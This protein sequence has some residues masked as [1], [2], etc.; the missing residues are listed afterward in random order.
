MENEEW[1]VMDE[2]DGKYSVSSSGRIK[3][4]K[5]GYV[6]KPQVNVL[7]YNRM[8]FHITRTTVKS[9][10]VHRLVAKYF[11]LASDKPQINHKD[12]NPNKD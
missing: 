7:G 11:M 12:G 2:L 10:S 5:T 1:K 6:R 4:N 9:Y 8:A 3:N